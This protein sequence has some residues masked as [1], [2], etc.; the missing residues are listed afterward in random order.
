M[1]I[2]ETA[3]PAFGSRGYEGA[4]VRRAE[5]EAETSLARPLYHFRS[6]KELWQETFKSLRSLGAPYDMAA[7]YSGP[8]ATERL[9]SLIRST[10]ELHAKSPTTQRLSLNDSF[11]LSDRV[12][13]LYKQGGKANFEEYCDVIRQ[14]QKEGTVRD[15]DPGKLRFMITAMA[16]NSFSIA[17]GYKITTG[18][19][20]FSHVATFPS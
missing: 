11:E 3:I 4:S 12:V 20:A 18:R 5:K 8:A 13:W 1:K 2:I 17:A 15:M 6:K 19:S 14:A 7:T 9:M 10:V 16:S